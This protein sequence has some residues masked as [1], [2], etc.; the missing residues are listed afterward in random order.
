MRFKGYSLIVLICFSY[1]MVDSVWSFL[2]FEYNLKNLIFSEPVSWIDTFLLQVPPY[3]MV[4]RLIVVGLFLCLGSIIFEFFIKMK[5]SE[6]AL[7]SSH[8]RFL[9]VLDGIDATVYVADMETYEILFMNKCMIETF[10][11]DMTGE[12]CWKAFRDES[13]PCP[14]CPKGKLTSENGIYPDVHVWQTK[15]PITNRWYINYDRMIE[16]TDDRV[17]KLQIATDITDL[18]RMEEELRQSHKMESIGTLTGGIAHD[19]NNILGII[20][21][22]VELALIDVS[23]AK[24]ANKSLDEIMKASL[25]AKDIVRQLLKFSRKTELNKKPQKLSTLISEEMKFLRSSIP[26]NIEVFEQLDKSKNTI[27]ADAT[28]IQQII[29]NVVTNAVQA[30]GEKD[31]RLEICLR[32]TIIKET[33]QGK[34]DDLAPGNYQEL[35]VKDSGPGIDKKIQD[36]IFDPY[37]TTKEVGKGSGMGLS[38]VHGIV[39]SHDGAIYVDSFPGKGAS[40]SLFFPTLKTPQKE[41][42]KIDEMISYKGSEKI[43]FIDDESEIVDTN[44]KI[45][46]QLGYI[47]EGMTDPQEAIAKVK[48]DPDYFDLVIT[49]MTMPKINGREVSETIKKIRPNLPIILFSGHNLIT[50]DKQKK[51]MGIS[52]YAIKPVSVDKMART[53]RKVLDH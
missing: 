45:L 19:F 3:Q 28:Q 35:I 18:K 44:S 47:V 38:V 51:E 39:K 34:Y 13:Q 10:G 17:V 53:I 30:M 1:W 22:N 11:R 21:G 20:M 26:S 43:L 14:H 42:E 29:I 52:A 27:L 31:G 46:Q 5:N 25:R 32:D 36:K 9:T 40:F 49:D 8:K 33:K 4:S 6:K 15:N 50:D 16:W 41:S 37:F 24:T 2:S 7:Q 48:N 12:I 23:N